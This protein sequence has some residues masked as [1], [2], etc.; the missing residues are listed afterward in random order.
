MTDPTTVGGPHTGAAF[1]TTSCAKP[2]WR[3][4]RHAF[5]AACVLWAVLFAVVM[6][7]DVLP[8]LTATLEYTPSGGPPYA[9]GHVRDGETA[10]IRARG[11]CRPA[12]PD[13]ATPHCSD[14]G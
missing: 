14:A 3:M 6:L 9:I 11:E 10:S 7:V 2:A 13:R 8:L 12:R 5:A 4:R 1:R